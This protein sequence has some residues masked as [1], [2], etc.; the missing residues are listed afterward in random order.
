MAASNRQIAQLEQR[1]RDLQR[2]ITEL[3]QRIVQ[4]ANR[5]SQEHNSKIEALKRDTRLQI[6]ERE[7]KI[8]KLYEEKLNNSMSAQEEELRRE[9]SKLQNEYEEVCASVNIAKAELARQ[10]EE[11]SLEQKAF[12][13]A[14]FARIQAQKQIAEQIYADIIK[15]YNQISSEMPMEWFAPGH[16]KLYSGR[17]SDIADRI[18]NTWYEIASAAGENISLNMRLDKL[19]INDKFNRWLNVYIVICGMLERL[20]ELLY[21]EVRL[22]PAKAETVAEMFGIP[23]R[24]ISDGLLNVWLPDYSELCNAYLVLFK[25][26]DCFLNDGKFIGTEKLVSF[27]QN[28]HELYASRFREMDLYVIKR[29]CESLLDRVVTSISKLH[30]MIES[31]EERM[32]MVCDR[33]DF[34]ILTLLE[35]YGYSAT[36]ITL[37]DDKALDTSI[38]IDFNDS[39]NT[40]T[41]QIIISPIFRIGDGTWINFVDWFYP[42][43]AGYDTVTELTH[44]MANA[45]VTKNI[46]V[47]RHRIEPGENTEKRTTDAYNEKMLLINGRTN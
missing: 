41:F 32:N 38:V 14:Y 23:E 27:M 40:M 12:E 47:A 30:Y 21:E 46:S 42:D 20:R 24:F 36:S 43:E 11:L 16:L 26:M 25:K 5:V 15:E 31:Y 4:E 2:S 3:N 28:N 34:G 13:E 37:S 33:S 19:E 6:Q 29:E 22:L 7:E 44:A 10:A 8:R 45:F 9:F 35:E 1:Q 17:I 18:R 39:F